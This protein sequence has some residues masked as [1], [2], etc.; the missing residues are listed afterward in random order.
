MPKLI[1]EPNKKSR[2]YKKTKNFKVDFNGNWIEKL[3][4]DSEGNVSFMRVWEFEYYN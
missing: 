1:I 2:Y 3:V 4:F